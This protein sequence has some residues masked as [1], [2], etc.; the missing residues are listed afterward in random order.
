EAQEA[1]VKRSSLNWTIVRPSGLTE[2]EPTG[3][4]VIGESIQ[5]KSSQI[6]CADVAHA[7][8]KELD[9]DAYVRMAVTIT[10]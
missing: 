7:I 6:A 9:E 2:G 8:V 10:N 1:V 4:Y 3:S 5:S